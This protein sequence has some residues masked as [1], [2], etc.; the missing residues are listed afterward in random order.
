MEQGLFFP[1]KNGDRKYKASDFTGYFSHLFSN[2]V[3]SNNSENLQVLASKTNGLAVVVGA[4]YGN[5]NGYLYQLTEAKTIVFKVADVSGTAKKG[6]VVLR[7]DLNE[8]LMSVETKGTTELTRTN[9][10][11]ELMLAEVAIPGGGLPITQSMIKDTRGNGELCGYVSSLIDIDPT[12]LWLQFEADWKK[13]LE[14]IKDL[15]DENEAAKLAL[16]IDELKKNIYKKSEIDA[17]LNEKQDSVVFINKLNYIAHRGA[18]GYAP[19]N[20]LPAFEKAK[21]NWGCE[22]DVH[23]TSDGHWVCMH[24][25]TIDRT[26]NGTGKISQFT[27]EQLKGFIIDAGNNI[28]NFS[29]LKIPTLEEYL[30]TMKKIGVIPVIEIKKANNKLDYDTLLEL[31]VSNYFEKSCILISFD[32]E[33]LKEIRKRNEFIQLQY[34]VNSITDTNIKDC[35]ELKNCDLDCLHT[36]IDKETVKKIHTSGL[37]LNTWTVNQREQNEKLKNMSVDFITTDLDFYR[38]SSELILQNK[39]KHE[40]EVLFSPNIIEISPNTFLLRLTV[41]DGTRTKGTLLTTLPEYARPN[42]FIWSTA[43]IRHLTSG[44]ISGTTDI[45]PDGEV[46]VGV[47]WD[48]GNAWISVEIVFSTL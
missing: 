7:M 21:G 33:A 8:R 35:Q 19:E 14:D 47:N 45:T 15:I 6:A 38:F 34:L 5:I 1:S 3:F 29:N 23:V 46:L 4:G 10:I 43:N 27:L 26:T 37:K 40:N 48:K 31:I 20:T 13:W 16:A 2:G 36:A 9:S 24:D 30:I 25:D 22:T 39:W 44:I 12:T 28:T 17:F 18:S 11:Y 41:K 32:L 42:K